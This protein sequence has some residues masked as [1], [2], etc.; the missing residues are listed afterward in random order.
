M[1]RKLDAL[2]KKLSAIQRENEKLKEPANGETDSSGVD[3][4][5]ED[6]VDIDFVLYHHRD[7]PRTIEVKIQGERVGA[8]D[9]FAQVG[10][11]VDVV[12]YMQVYAAADADAPEECVEFD[13]YLISDEIL[14]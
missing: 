3:Q 9:N 5:I 2:E 11:G 10:Y 12:P 14:G 6:G 4:T 7:A 13:L 8:F 1:Q